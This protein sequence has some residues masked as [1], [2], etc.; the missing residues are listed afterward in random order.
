M[1]PGTETVYQEY[2]A[3]FAGYSDD[4]DTFWAKAGYPTA[5]GAF[6]SKASGGWD[7]DSN[8]VQQLNGLIS[9]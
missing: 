9:L 3:G 6:M 7:P 8:L 1:H 5:N 4:Q 2:K